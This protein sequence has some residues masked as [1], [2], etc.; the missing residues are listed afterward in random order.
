MIKG[1]SRYV[2]HETLHQKIVLIT[3]FWHLCLL[4]CIFLLIFV[5]S[6]DTQTTKTARSFC[7]VLKGEIFTKLHSSTGYR[8][9]WRPETV[10]NMKCVHVS[11]HNCIGSKEI[12]SPQQNRKRALFS[13]QKYFFF[14]FQVFFFWKVLLFPKVLFKR[15]A[16]HRHFP[17]L[18]ETKAWNRGGVWKLLKTSSFY[19][20]RRNS[21]SVYWDKV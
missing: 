19:A 7:V 20:Q 14:I 2:F 6:S 17:N 3:F 1:I 21:W 8:K 10:E 5:E 18:L 12:N 11:Y 9:F 4:L 16:A 15:H 13:R